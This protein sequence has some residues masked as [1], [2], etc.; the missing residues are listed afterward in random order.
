MTRQTRDIAVSPY[1]RIAVSPY[2]RIAVSPY[3]RFA[4]SPFRHIPS[5]SCHLSFV[6]GLAHCFFDVEITFH[7]HTPL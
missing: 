3:R 4:V 2:R 5:P 7:H 1:R 6:I